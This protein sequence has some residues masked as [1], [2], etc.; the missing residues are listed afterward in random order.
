LTTNHPDII[1][2]SFPK[3]A[4]RLSVV[5]LAILLIPAIS[6]AQLFT[7]N[8][9]AS[10]QGAGCYEL[11]PNAKGQLGSVWS[12]N[13]VS[14]N[15]SFVVTGRLNFGTKPFWEK[16]ADGIAFAL[17]PISANVGNPGAALGVG[18]ITP[19]LVV[20]FDTYANGWDPGYHHAAIVQNGQPDHST[21][22]PLDG[23]VGIKAGNGNVTDGQWYNCR[24][25]WDAVAQKF[26][27][28]IN[29]VEILSY[30][31]D[32]IQDVFGGISDVHWGF[33]AATGDKFS[34]HQVCIDA[35]NLTDIPDQTIC[36]GDSATVALTSL[37]NNYTINSWNPTVGILSTSPVTPNAT[38]SP[39]VTTEYIL[40]LTDVCND[41]IKDTFNLTID[42]APTVSLGNDTSVCGAQNITLDA[43]NVGSTY[44]WNTGA[45]S[46]TI[47]TTGAGTY[48][49][50]VT[51]ST[52]CSVSDTISVSTGG[53]LTVN[54]GPDS[55]FCGTINL[56]LDA[57]NPGNTYLWNTG[58]STQNIVAGAIGSYFVE[59]TTNSGCKGYDTIVVTQTTGLVVN[60]GNDTSI[61]MG[62]NITFDAGNPGSTYL[63]NT[64]DNTQNI[65]VGASGTYG[66]TVTNSA[67]CQGSDSIILTTNTFPIVNLGTDLTLCSG[68]STTLDAGA[69][70]SNYLWN[71]T[72]T[73]QTISI[74]IGG[75]YYVDV[76]TNNCSSSDT[77]IVTSSSVVVS[78]G[79][80]T[81]ICTGSSLALD[82]ANVGSTYLWNNGTVGQTLSVNTAGQ[83]YVDVTNGD[84]CSES[85][86]IE[87]SIGSL[88]I[89]LGVD[90]AL[91]TGESFGLDATTPNA[92][93]L[94]NTGTTAATI[95]ASIVGTYSV[96]VTVNG[97]CVGKDTVI[98]TSKAGPVVSL[99]MDTTMCNGNNLLLD[100]G[101]GN[102]YLWNTTSTNQT[103]L[104]SSPGTY[105]VG[106]TSAGANCFGTDTIIVQFSNSL[107]VQLGNDTTV[108]SGNNLIINTGIV[109]ATYLW[110]TAET[111][112]GITVSLAGTYDVQV[113]DANNCEGRDT[114]IV[115]LGV[116]PIVDLGQ[117]I[118]SCN[119]INNTLDASN[120]GSTFFWST[121][122]LTQSI[123][124]NAAG[125]YYVDVTN[126][127]NCTTRDSITLAL[128]SSNMTVDLGADSTF[129]GTIFYTRNAANPGSS[130]EWST[131]AVNQS[132]NIIAAG[133]YF[134]KVTDVNGCVKSDTININL[135]API[136]VDLGNEQNLCE[137]NSATL[138]ALNNGSTFLWSD[139]T[140]ARTLM[141]GLTGIYSVT[142]RNS[143]NCEATDQVSIIVAGKP[144][145]NMNNS[146]N[147]AC[148]DDTVIVSS[149]NTIDTH[150]WSDGTTSSTTNVTN[151][152]DILTLTLTNALGCTTTGTALPVNFENISVDL[153]DVHYH[154]TGT[155]T[156][157]NPN[158]ID[159]NY[160]Y[161]WQSPG[162]NIDGGLNTSLDGT[163]VVTALLNIGTKFCSASDSTTLISVDYPTITIEGDSIACEGESITIDATAVN[164]VLWSDGST[165][166]QHTVT[167]SGVI[168]ASTSLTL[169]GNTCT[170]TDSLSMSFDPFPE[171]IKT[172]PLSHCFEYD[173]NFTVFTN[174]VADNYDWSHSTSTA[175]IAGV[176]NQGLYSVKVYNNINCAVTQ[177]IEVNEKCPISLFVPNTF[178]PNGD[179]INETFAI[180]GHNA[181]TYELTIFN[182][183]G[184]I[185][186]Q[187]SDGNEHWNGTIDGHIVPQDVYVWMAKIT[188][189]DENYH[190]KVIDK[191]G[192]ITLIR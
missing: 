85:D 51:N 46:Q 20:E 63:W 95:D 150:L 2:S 158:S 83:Y 37:G 109:G 185:V 118:T 125:L 110:N 97:G 58:A 30:S 88:S 17:Q 135:G 170:T 25:E 122:V 87:V 163:H 54:L 172:D 184:E 115:T 105:Y 187:S 120:T 174:I 81:T 143:D 177:E 15:N 168:Y 165:G 57:G 173:H 157:L 99:G 140:T 92:T 86:S 102:S 116:S 33:S 182:R 100:A 76:T 18:G 94:W 132:I 147:I 44:T 151:G 103:I 91:C 35:T 79:S 145:I 106:V 188:G 42:N 31:G 12:P 130:Y 160:T 41:E 21:Y 181:E 70:A 96:I 29:C 39:T 152:H 74:N 19:A 55:S 4:F 27:V 9:D 7:V 52:G 129:C 45:I 176:Q 127:D 124:T 137:G 40:T 6:N 72:A 11:T 77:I 24:F 23:P 136:V 22:T 26:T 89:N 166:N 131:G 141:V 67:G 191:T 38:F 144:V 108:C 134:V 179:G 69:G 93:Y 75:T 68:I 146:T 183:W 186:F 73:S 149:G 8:G 121:G 66:L 90:T 133:Q 192:T 161:T 175:P 180:V 28:D 156:I 14:L 153:N 36:L 65:I 48:F 47:N 111:S 53:A 167:T 43:G 16:G 49:A 114:V 64:G 142:V 78:I 32:M 159:P 154:C 62:D 10:D 71:T 82:A 59:V 80:D 119:E 190:N 84:G 171:V 1:K 113:T 148:I 139:G 128:S 164:S 98:V 13:K 117:D 178:S 162:D 169:N 101:A 104:V 126:T 123:S 3:N 60:L 34:H 112:Q 189:Y 56:N 107:S 5:L 138:D 155:T 50:E 61:C